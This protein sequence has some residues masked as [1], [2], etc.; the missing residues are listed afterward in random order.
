[1]MRTRFA[2]PIRASS[3]PGLHQQAGHM[4]A[5]DL[6]AA[7]QM[8]SCQAGPST[9]EPP[10][11]H[12]AVLL[13]VIGPILGWADRKG[14]SDCADE[15]TLSLKG[16][17]SPTRGRKLRS[18]GTKATAR[19]SNGP[20]S[21]VELKKQLEVRTREL[22][23]A[24]GHLSEALE[25]QTATYEALQV[26]SSS[27][28][29]LQPVFDAMLEKATRICGA[30]FGVLQL[31]DG[32]AFRTVAMHNPPPAYLEHKRRDPMVRPSP[33]TALGRLAQ[34]KQTVHIADVLNEQGFF[35]VPAGFTGPVL[36]TLAGAR[37][38]VAVPMLKESELVG[39]I[40]IYRQ[41]AQPFT[42]KQIALVTNFAAQAVIAIENTRLLDELRESLQQQTATADVLK[43]ISRST[44]DLQ[45]VLDTLV[46]SAARLCEADMTAIHRLV[47][48]NYQHA[49]SHGYPPDLHDRMT[50]IRFAPGQGTIAGRTALEAS[51]VH[52]TDVL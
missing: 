17:N 1:M 42:D 25:Q 44:F 14:S 29:E 41:Q 19:V 6:C 35:E 50:K 47:G 34:T 15:V 21:L 18:S 38:L 43:V 5:S 52:V 27:P 16:A 20:N 28:G 8:I 39:A 10:R 48:S 36:A 13:R 26:I 7:R 49:A 30:D 22:A 9:H 2:H 24:R 4:T 51:V 31:C 45:A 33:N 12:H 23:E 40:I 11:V 3:P 46:Q 37:T 32:D